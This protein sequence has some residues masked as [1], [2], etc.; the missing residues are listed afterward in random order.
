MKSIIKSVTI[1]KNV[2]TVTVKSGM[3]RSYR[4][5]NVLIAQLYYQNISA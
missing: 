1:A 3:V 2:V 4:F 5:P